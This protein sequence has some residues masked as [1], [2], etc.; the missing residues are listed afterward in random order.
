MNAVY[1][2]L[3]IAAFLWISYNL[4]RKRKNR[5]KIIC[6]VKSNCTGCRSCIRRCSHHVL[7]MTKDETGMH[8][9]VKYPNKCSACGDC[10]G[11]CKFN[12]LRLIERDKNTPF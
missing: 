9:V 4:H 1:I 7:G 5:N 3:G 6:V 10:L 8:A 2:G 12:A 11:K